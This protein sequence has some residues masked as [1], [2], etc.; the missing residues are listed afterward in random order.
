MKYKVITCFLLWVL[1][2]YFSFTYQKHTYVEN[3][4]FSLYYKFSIIDFYFIFINNLSVALIMAILGYFSF[5]LITFLVTFY[6]GFLL[7]S[8][9][10]YYVLENSIIKFFSNMLHGPIEISAFC[11]FGA[12]GLTG[13]NKSF[14]FKTSSEFLTLLKSK[15]MFIIVA[16]LLLMLAAFIESS[17]N[18]K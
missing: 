11:M 10:T 14:N 17:L 9:A 7:G 5:G 18:V 1:G 15:F 12:I 3:N 6:N 8:I 13:F 4:D 16:L 2:F